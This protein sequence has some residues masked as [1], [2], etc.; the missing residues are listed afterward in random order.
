MKTKK[1]VWSKKKEYAGGAIV[2]YFDQLLG[3]KRTQ[4]LVETPMFFFISAEK[5]L[6]T[7]WIAKKVEEKCFYQL[8][9]ACRTWKRSRQNQ[10]FFVRFLLISAVKSLKKLWN[11][12]KRLKN[13]W[14]KCFGQLSGAASTWKLVEIHNIYRTVLHWP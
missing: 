3:A 11:E 1:T 10:V 2:V 9:C 8:L 5:S 6:K 4:M 13:S 14:K 7:I 12:Q